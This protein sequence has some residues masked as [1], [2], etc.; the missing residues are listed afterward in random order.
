MLMKLYKLTG[1]FMELYKLTAMLMKLYKLTGVTGSFCFEK[2]I[3]KRA[4]PG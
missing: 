2:W 4:N 1:V 3:T